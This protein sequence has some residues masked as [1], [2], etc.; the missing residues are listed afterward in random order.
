[1]RR[2]KFFAAAMAMG[3][4]LTQLP[5]TASADASKVVTLG[6]DL[7]TEQRDLIMNYFGASYDGVSIIYVNN[8]NERDLLSSY[9][10]LEQIGTH[11]YSCAYVMPTTSGGIHVKTANLSYVTCNMIATT[12]STCGVTNAEVIAACPFE[13]SGTGALT[14]IIMA[15]ETATGETLDET[16][17]QLAVEELVVTGD[18]GE[19]IGQDAATAIVN[20]AKMEVLDD[21]LEDQETLYSAVEE[22][23]SNNGYELT[24]EELTGIADLLDKMKDQ[25]Y[26]YSSMQETLSMVEE[27]VS[28]T[29]KAEEL[30]AVDETEEATEAPK[31]ETDAEPAESIL[32]TVDESVFGEDVIF[33]STD[34]TVAAA[35]TEAETEALAELVPAETEGTDIWEEQTEYVE[36]VPEETEGLELVVEDPAPEVVEEVTEAAPVET[37]AAPVETEAAAPETESLTLEGDGITEIEEV[38]TETEHT[39]DELTEED[40]EDYD[41]LEEYCDSHFNDGD[42]DEDGNYKVPLDEETA[43]KAKEYLLKLFLN[44]KLDGL[45]DYTAPEDAA[46][47]SDELNYLDEQMK[48]L[49]AE[50]KDSE[51][52][53]MFGTYSDEDCQVLYDSVMKFFRQM[54]EEPTDE[55]AAELLSDTTDTGLEEIGGTDGIAEDG[56]ADLEELS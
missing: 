35:D 49:F 29:E 48:A 6:V 9:I 3:L 8:Q 21:E 26:D 47:E 28:G 10:P 19:R 44:L 43:A 53:P 16:K 36:T 38:D 27:N 4:C 23:A 32:D 39:P 54:Y 45:G 11:T 12:L 7:S 31:A 18:L 50:H 15:Y 41:S 56:A 52:S 33:G 30:T 37:E 25:D 34:E 40:R 24:D 14:G 55:E 17:K 5:L 42:M 46:Y 13:V 2:T 51:E 20:E 22:A 1:M